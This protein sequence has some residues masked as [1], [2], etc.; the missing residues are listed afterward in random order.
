MTGKEKIL[1]RQKN[2]HHRKW[3]RTKLCSGP[4]MRSPSEVRRNRV[5][6]YVA[7]SQWRWYW[8]FWLFLQP[9]LHTMYRM[10]IM[11][12]NLR[13]EGGSCQK[14]WQVFWSP[15][16]EVSYIFASP[17]PAPSVSISFPLPETETT[18]QSSSRA[19]AFRHL[20]WI[21]WILKMAKENI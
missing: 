18:R 6:L 14:F 13:K 2:N 15:L 17:P 4:R 21:I 8:K 19:R 5:N 3:T 12:F 11:M 1:D 9:V 7:E 20:A 16:C 10:C